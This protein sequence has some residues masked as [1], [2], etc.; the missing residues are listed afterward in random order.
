MECRSVHQARATLAR[1][2]DEVAEHHHP[3]VIVGQRHNAVL[4][5]QTDWD[6]M[7]ETLHLSSIPGLVESI[8]NAAQEPL[9]GCTKLQDLEGWDT[10]AR[11]DAGAQEPQGRPAAH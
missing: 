4:V 8:Q 9:D 2:I 1:L 7:Q 11:P 10:V 5:A 3:V 6:A